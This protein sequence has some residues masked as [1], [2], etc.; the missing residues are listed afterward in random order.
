MKKFILIL[1]A[2]LFL[3]ANA[4]EK[5]QIASDQNPNYMVSQ[6]KYV[7]QAE[8]LQKTM[9]TTQQQ[10]YKA[11]DWYEAKLEKKENRIKT[12]QQVRINRS[13][14]N[15][16]YYRNNRWNDRNFYNPRVGYRTNNWWFWY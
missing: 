2:G 6:T 9:N 12:R 4:Q 15:N 1:T 11:Y 10:T 3:S 8:E 13:L 16:F 14:S 7:K 5:E